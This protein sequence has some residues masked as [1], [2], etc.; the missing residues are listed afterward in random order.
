MKTG[1]L[2][3]KICAC[4]LLSILFSAYAGQEV[5]I[6]T[7]D[8]AHFPAFAGDLLPDNGAAAQ[9]VDRCL[10]DDFCF[11]PFLEQPGCFFASDFV[12]LAVL[13]PKATRCRCC[14]PCGALSLRAPPAA[15]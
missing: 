1:S 8:R 15:G 2:L 4:L 14:L 5:H 3:Q 7:E 13:R 12:L 11:F 6:Y 9:V 10:I